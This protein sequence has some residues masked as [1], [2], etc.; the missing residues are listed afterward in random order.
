MTD[1]SAGGEADCSGQGAGSFGSAQMVK[2]R[3]VF[4][5]TNTV[6]IQYFKKKLTC[7]I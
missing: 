4:L 5:L 7:L 1:P 3:L 6:F 2:K